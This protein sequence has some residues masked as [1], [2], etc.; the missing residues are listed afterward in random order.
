MSMDAP[1]GT[2]ERNHPAGENANLAT[3]DVDGRKVNNPLWLTSIYTDLNM[4]LSTSQLKKGIV[5]R[6]IR[7]TERF[8][9]FSAVW[10]V[11]DR[12]KYVAFLRNIR[13]HWAYSLNVEKPRPMQLTYYGAGKVFQGFIQKGDIGYTVQDVVLTYSFQMRL[14]SDTQNAKIAKLSTFDSPIAPTIGTIN[15]YG[16]DWYTVDE[17]Q[18]MVDKVFGS[19]SNADKLAADAASVADSVSSIQQQAKEVNNG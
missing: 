10:N 13:N 7:L 4:Q 11:R 14:V 19:N 9:T 6:P 12:Q 17:A 2:Q 3:T 5:Y 15:R 8:L 1:L 16:S 18:T